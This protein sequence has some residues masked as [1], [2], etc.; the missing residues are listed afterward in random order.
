VRAGELNNWS[1][2]VISLLLSIG[3][4]FGL[5][6]QANLA[7]LGGGKLVGFIKFDENPIEVV[8]PVGD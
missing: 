3:A 7:A 4:R 5:V 8:F 6:S 2:I 1:K